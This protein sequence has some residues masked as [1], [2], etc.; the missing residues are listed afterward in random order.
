LAGFLLGP[1]IGGNQILKELAIDFPLWGRGNPEQAA[2]FSISTEEYGS[3][4]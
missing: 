2:V 3:W 4:C 1:V